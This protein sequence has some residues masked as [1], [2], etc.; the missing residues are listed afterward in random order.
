MT[1]FNM[2]TKFYESR[3]TKYL[4]GLKNAHE[5]GEGKDEEYIK[6]EF[7]NTVMVRRNTNVKSVGLTVLGEN[8]VS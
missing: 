6:N 1:Y 5:E 3:F 4:K 7:K 2:M 8:E